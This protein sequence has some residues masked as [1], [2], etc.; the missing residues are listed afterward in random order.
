MPQPHVLILDG[1]LLL[2]CFGRFFSRLVCI[3]F[4]RLFCFLFLLCIFFRLVCISRFCI[5]FV[6]ANCVGFLAG[7]ATL[8]RLLL[9]F[10][11]G[12]SSAVFCTGSAARCGF[13]LSGAAGTGL[14]PSAGCS[15]PWDN[16]HTGQKTRDA[17]TGED[18][19]HLLAVH[20]VLLNRNRDLP[21]AGKVF[22]YITLKINR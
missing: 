17:Q 2:R 21:K 3:G 15:I 1:R 13:L 16:R 6:R 19:F 14:C 4:L 18:S 12:A 9:N 8:G 22:F 7:S 5:F 10:L 11:F 20:D